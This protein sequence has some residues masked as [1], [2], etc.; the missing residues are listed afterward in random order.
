MQAAHT[1]VLAAINARLAKP[2]AVK[3][4]PWKESHW[5]RALPYAYG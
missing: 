5:S 2:W 1:T 3:P 4:G